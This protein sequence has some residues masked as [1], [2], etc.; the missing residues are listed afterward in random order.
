MEEGALATA[1]DPALFPKRAGRVL[2]QVALHQ[3]I[4]DMAVAMK[5]QAEDIAEIKDMCTRI[6]DR[7]T[8]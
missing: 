7:L 6:L 4:S 8:V 3:L 5:Q 1:F 2:G